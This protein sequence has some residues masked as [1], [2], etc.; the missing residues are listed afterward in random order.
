MFKMCVQHSRMEDFISVKSAFSVMLRHQ[1]GS[2]LCT[3]LH[4]QH[5]VFYSLKYSLQTH[6]TLLWLVYSALAQR[7]STDFD[8]F[9]QA[10]C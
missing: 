6:A 5:K 9:W 3:P 4:M 2:S 8:N 10:C 1:Y 7:T